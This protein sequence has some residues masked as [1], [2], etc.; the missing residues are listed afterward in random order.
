M[1]RLDKSIENV[2]YILEVLME[3]RKIVESGCCNDCRMRYSCEHLPKLGQL[4]RYNCPFYER[5]K[6]TNE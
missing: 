1:S 5:K 6:G 3:Y 2:S 4:V